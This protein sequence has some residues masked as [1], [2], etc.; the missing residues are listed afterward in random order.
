M[1]IPEFKHL[2]MAGHHVVRKNHS[3]TTHKVPLLC[4]HKSESIEKSQKFLR[5]NRIKETQTPR[6]GNKR[7]FERFLLFTKVNQK[8]SLIH[9][10]E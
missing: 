1:K 3:P 5:K 9:F 10:S 7:F 4:I 8:D 2:F 6:K